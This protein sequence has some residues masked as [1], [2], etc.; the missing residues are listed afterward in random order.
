MAG[1]LE[2]PIFGI[3]PGQLPTAIIRHGVELDAGMN[4]HNLIL[5]ALGENCITGGIPLLFLVGLIIHRSWKLA[6]NRHTLLTACFCL[7]ITC[8]MIHNLV[9]ASWEGEQFQIIF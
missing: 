8:A 5:N 6:W 1:F 4:A 3:G 2:N 7:S 9:E